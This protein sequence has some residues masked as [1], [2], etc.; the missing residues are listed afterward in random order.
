[1]IEVKK[2]KDD[3]YPKIIEFL[4]NEYLNNR[5]EKSWLA[6]RWED[7]EF[8]VDVLNT[9]ERHKLS[10]HRNI[11]LWLDDGNIVAILNSEGGPEC[12]M[13]IHKGY[14]LLFEEML[15]IAEKNIAEKGKTLVVYALHSQVYKENML[16]NYD[17]IKNDNKEEI[18]FFK[19][20]RCN[21]KYPV[22]VPKGFK[23]IV[24]TEKLNH[25]EILNACGYGF[26][27]D[28]EG[29]YNDN[30]LSASWKSRE[31]AP[32]F[33]YK[34]E[35]IA[36]APN[37]ETASYSYVWV[38]TVTKTGYIEPVSTRLKYRRL[39]LGK[40]IQQETLNLMNKMGVEYCY[41][42]PYGETRNKFYT[43]AGYRTFDYEYEY[44]KQF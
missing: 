2:Y 30:E 12:W 25:I 23:L 14:E 16:L 1:M 4:R 27:P 38:D 15:Q 36:I 33:D 6:Q 32:M 24:G 41:V 31:N 10:W 34:Y 19:R 40:A 42:N 43:S 35:V 11:R 28:E 20:A 7:M 21:K 29:K 8:R 18:G 22:F 26:H 3:Y 37:G 13:H 9:I 5:D 39:G 44:K 17:Y